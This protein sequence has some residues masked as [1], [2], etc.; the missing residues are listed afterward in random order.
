MQTLIIL[1]LLVYI[2]YLHY[3]RPEIDRKQ[4]V[5]NY[6][7]AIVEGERLLTA[8]ENIVLI[9]KKLN[10]MKFEDVPIWQKDAFVKTI[11]YLCDKKVE[12]DSSGN[13]QPN[14]SSK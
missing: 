11:L 3:T 13:R 6:I 1:I 4:I 14:I 5:D 2:A 7:Q 9:M 12:N 8:E 10:A